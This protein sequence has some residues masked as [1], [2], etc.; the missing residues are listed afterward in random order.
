[1]RNFDLWQNNF[2]QDGK[3]LHGKI[4]FTERDSS[5]G[6]NVPNKKEIYD[7][8]GTPISNPVLTD[9]YGKTERQVF[10][11]DG[12][13]TVWR[14][15]YIG[16]GDFSDYELVNDDS[17]W[18]LVDSF[19]IC[20]KYAE[21][22]IELD[23]SKCVKVDTVEDLK[24]LNPA[25]VEGETKVVWLLGY[26]A[27]GDKRPVAY[28]SVSSGNPDGGSVIRSTA[29]NAVYWKLLNPTNYVD[30][31][32]F[33]VFPDD[34]TNVG[35]IANAISYANTN[36]LDV[37]FPAGG[38]E[39]NGG[40]YRIYGM[41]LVDQGVIFTGKNGTSTSITAD[42]G[43]NPDTG[44]VIASQ[45]TGYIVVTAP[46]VHTKWLHPSG[47]CN[48]SATDTL[49]IDQDVELSSFWFGSPRK[50]IVTASSTK[51]I[52]FKDCEIE[53]S[54]KLSSTVAYTFNNCNFTDKFFVGG[55]FSENITLTNCRL[56]INDF[57]SVD[58]WAKAML[59]NGA[60][61]LDFQGKLCQS[62]E[63]RAR[64]VG[65]SYRVFNGFFG[66]FEMLSDRTSS[67]D[68]DLELEQCK[69]QNLVCDDNWKN[70]T[71]ID[72][73]V[74][75]GEGITGQ[76]DKYGVYVSGGLVIR[77]S[78]I[79]YNQDDTDKVAI[80]P[81]GAYPF[82]VSLVDTRISG[83]VSGESVDALRCVFDNEVYNNSGTM[84]VCRCV[85][86]ENSLLKTNG[87]A[88]YIVDNRFDQSGTPDD[89]VKGNNLTSCTYEGNTGNCLKKKMRIDA[90][91][92]LRLDFL[93]DNP[94]TI[95][96]FILSMEQNVNEIPL[97]LFGVGT[98]RIRV[99]FVIDVR[100][101]TADQSA[102]SAQNYYYTVIGSLVYDTTDP[103]TFIMPHGDSGAYKSIHDNDS[104]NPHMIGVTVPE[105]VYTT[106]NKQ[107][108][109]K[110][111]EAEIIE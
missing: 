100:D 92:L 85:L 81:I 86:A 19:D 69:I 33:G 22:Q 67:S 91:N 43:V 55:A 66:T 31:R 82:T 27:K 21:L 79:A 23:E 15:R 58:N 56:D 107:I 40:S 70:L 20:D 54:G 45:G 97:H 24:S 103:R 83:K 106:T 34:A 30:V 38:Y 2:D 32:D 87:T 53:C 71:I 48:V 99:S 44:L 41:L 68:N 11:G 72:S 111:I 88:A 12:E 60:S 90:E 29:D 59:M 14:Y 28:K 7:E 35:Q 51:A 13:Y 47:T 63:I 76:G 109:G 9:T 8:D 39:F 37:Y 74:T 101:S 1:M 25:L 6:V 94:V 4:L 108:L 49:V 61:E 50:C 57:A 42:N 75:A 65:T 5:G 77:N 46:E 17:L 95:R 3:F 93:D 10:I 102:S 26:N 96:R 104:T 110:Y 16:G 36:G 73:D 105:G 78:N 18:E 52:A 80:G 62:F 64:N 98:S 84:S 89:A